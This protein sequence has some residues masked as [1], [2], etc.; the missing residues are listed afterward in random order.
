MSNLHTLRV[1]WPSLRLDDDP[2]KVMD[3]FKQISLVLLENLTK[4]GIGSV[5]VVVV[6]MQIVHPVIQRSCQHVLRKRHVILVIDV[7]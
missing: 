4:E 5:L 1:C 2:Q 3:L 7:S 6:V